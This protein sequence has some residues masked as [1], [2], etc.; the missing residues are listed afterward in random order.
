MSDYER[1]QAELTESIALYDRSILLAN[2]ATLPFLIGSVV[3]GLGA[4]L[5]RMDVVTTG[6]GFVVLGVVALSAAVLIG[7]R[8]GAIS[9]GA[10]A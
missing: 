9:R 10:G 4:A 8:A 1:H 2:L 3:C 7:H 5:R 6:I